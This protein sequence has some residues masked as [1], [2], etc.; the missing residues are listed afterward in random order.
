MFLK[1]LQLFNTFKLCL[2]FG[3]NGLLR[4]IKC[5]LFVSKQE[6][7]GVLIHLPGPYDS[8]YRRYQA[9]VEMPLIDPCV[10]NNI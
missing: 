8:I 9:I 5:L 10:H 4:E 1:F 2:W 3:N 6:F 7:R